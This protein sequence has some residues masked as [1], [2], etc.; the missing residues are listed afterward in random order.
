VK[1]VD[2]LLTVN[3]PME[4]CVRFVGNRMLVCD[5]MY[6]CLTADPVTNQLSCC[7]ACDKRRANSDVGVVHFGAEWFCGQI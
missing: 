1:P 3:L 7:W 5:I 2:F 4:D 6:T